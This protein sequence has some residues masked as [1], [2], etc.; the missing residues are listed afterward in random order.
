MIFNQRYV[1]KTLI[2][3]K[4]M[5]IIIILELPNF[6]FLQFNRVLLQ[7]SYI[8]CDTHYHEYQYKNSFFTEH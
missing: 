8:K 5:V 1:E 3:E 4:K 7:S 2:W 6:Y